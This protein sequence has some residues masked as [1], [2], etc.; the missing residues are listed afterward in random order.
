MLHVGLDVHARETSIGVLDKDGSTQMRR[1]VTGHWNKVLDVL[2]EI[3][4][5]F[6]ACQDRRGGD[7]ALSLARHA[8][9]AH[10]GRTLA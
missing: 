5:P 4:R 1:R 3:K 6:A 2:N 9:D 8:G 10:H 7:R